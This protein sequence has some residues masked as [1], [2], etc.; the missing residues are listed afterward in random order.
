MPELEAHVEA[1]Q[2]YFPT[3]KLDPNRTEIGVKEYEL[4]AAALSGD[5]RS[6]AAA[7][8]LLVLAVGLG[9]SLLGTNIDQR[10]LSKIIE[11][12]A[13]PVE[14]I[15]LLM[16]STIGFLSISYFS[17]LQRSA[18]Y[19]ARKIVVLRRLMGIDYGTIETVLPA[20]RIEGANEPFAIPMFPGWLALSTIPTLLLSIS[21]GVLTLLLSI[22]LSTT[23]SSNFYAISAALQMKGN[24]AAYTTASIAFL[25]PM[26]GYR[27][28]L[29]EPYESYRLSLGRLLGLVTK[30]RLKRRIGHVLYRMNLSVHEARRI[31]VELKPFHDMI[32]RIEDRRFLLHNGNSWMALF[33]AAWRL[34]KY[35]KTSGGSTI[36]H[37][38]IRSNFLSR[39]RPPLPRKLL[40]WCL[41]PWV[42]TLYSK[43]EML[44]VY[45][46]SVR[47]EQ[48]VIGLPA[49]ITHFFPLHDFK[50]ELSSAQR[51]F[52]IE[53]LS[54]VT[55]SFPRERVKAL[56]ADLL[57]EGLLKAAD[58]GP[59][60]MLYAEQA[61][62][63]RI[64]IRDGL[65]PGLAEQ[66]DDGD[67]R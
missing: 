34:Y 64:R 5:Q 44:D 8:G 7:T 3:Y 63:G 25:A 16:I 67:R 42:G 39:L 38:I 51:F 65:P 37:Q 20:D 45:L 6:L 49:A 11:Q 57:V 14:V 1:A 41:G 31:G 40:E 26:F 15:C 19:A 22:F 17:G 60:N 21:L 43:L 24:N 36:E 4:S 2:Q 9:S 61:Q 56:I 53:R 13:N 59:L 10:K 12:Y 35:K 58:L 30:V 32:I 54:N 28:L 50:D 33:S 46:C 52:L 47:F 62:A 48:G 23:P 18:T 29:F 27:R 55:A 66:R